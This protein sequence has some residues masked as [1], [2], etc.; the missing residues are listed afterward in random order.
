MPENQTAQH[1]ALVEEFESRLAGHDEHLRS[2]MNALNEKL[3]F[4]ENVEL[5]KSQ[6]GEQL[7]HSERGREELRRALSEAAD[8]VKEEQ[9]KNFKYQEI[10]IN[11]NQSL[12]K[13]ILIITDM[14]SK[15][16]EEHD[17]LK[18]AIAIKDRENNA[19]SMERT[20]LVDFKGKYLRE[21]A[22]RDDL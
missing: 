9:D 14:F 22:Q 21:T 18:Q 4:Y 17:E 2:A 13:Q 6:L 15:K 12:S 11:E 1:K 20:D 3:K 16:V 5:E 8:R 7:G 10:L 19:L